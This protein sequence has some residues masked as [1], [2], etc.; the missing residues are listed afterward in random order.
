MIQEKVEQQEREIQKQHRLAVEQ[1]EANLGESDAQS[2]SSEGGPGQKAD[3]AS[4]EPYRRLELIE[5]DEVVQDEDDIEEDV[6]VDGQEEDE[7]ATP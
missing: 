2:R 1:Y 4:G 6:A 3:G 7:D 5:N